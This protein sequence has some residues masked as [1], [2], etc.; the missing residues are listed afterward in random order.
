M[1]RS[2]MPSFALSKQQAPGISP[3][4]QAMQKLPFHLGLQ[5]MGYGHICMWDLAAAIKQPHE[6]R[7]WRSIR[8][9]NCICTQCLCF[10]SVLPDHARL[11]VTVH[12]QGRSRLEKKMWRRQLWKPCGLDCSALIW[13]LT[14]SLVESGAS[15]VFPTIS[16]CNAS[17]V[18][19]SSHT[20]NA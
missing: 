9:I 4:S 19:C 12:L 17:L 5:H 14:L 8:S 16:L 3:L 7:V 13:L 10:G 6:S 20:A 15:Q 1:L 18:L 2:S 11:H